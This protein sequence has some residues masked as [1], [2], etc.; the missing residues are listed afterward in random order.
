MKKKANILIVTY[1]FPPYTGIEGQRTASWFSE[2]YKQGVATEVITRMWPEDKPTQ[3]WED[4]QSTD[5]KNPFVV[6]SE[7]GNVHYLPH[8]H[9][10]FYAFSRKI[11]ILN[12][13]AYW[14]YK[15]FG[16]FHI[17]T[18]AYHSFKKY[19]EKLI[20]KGNFDFI[21]VSSPPLNLIR[22]GYELSKK[23]NVNLVADY[24]DTFDN[25]L[26]NEKTPVTFSRKI[27]NYFFRKYI[28][29]WTAIANLNLVVS[30]AMLDILPIPEGKSEVVYNGFEEDI[31][32]ELRKI[33]PD[34]MKFIIH[35]L[36][37]LYEFQAIDTMIEG[38]TLFYN[39]VSDKTSFRFDFIG[40]GTQHSI[41]E[42][43]RKAFPSDNLLITNRIKRSEALNHLAKASV[44]F[45]TPGAHGY[46]G[47]LGGKTFDYIGAGKYILICP[48]DNDI[49]QETIHC[50]KLGSIVNTAEEIKEV[51]L[52]E[53]ANW[54]NGIMFS[55]NFE[56]VRIFS[57]EYQST[58]LLNRIGL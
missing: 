32:L 23:Y 6:D 56:E 46:K 2:F 27:E 54:K 39:A 47:V 55:N 40:L 16:H 52:K 26:L 4:Y 9:R 3:N 33:E 30:P 11:P 20:S 25:K 42:K 38:Y 18:D 29:K 44:C 48:S 7:K 12:A 17:E 21:I 45:N 58:K 1:Y 10:K 36:G 41:S 53:Y 24:R 35:V 8:R 13:I 28:K 14:G 43:L 22:L 37:N 51:L 19:A 57:R 5:K 50:Y 49:V 34:K 15:F 31:F